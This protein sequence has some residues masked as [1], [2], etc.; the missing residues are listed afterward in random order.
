[1]ATFSDDTTAIREWAEEAL[2]IYRSLGNQW[3]VADALSSLGI[4]YGEGGDWARARPL[5]DESLQRF[6]EVG[7][8]VRAM[9]GTRSLAWATAEVG[10]LP[11]ARALYEDALRQGRAAGNRLLESVVLG[12]LSWLAI[13]EGRVADTPALLKESLRIKQDMGNLLE[14]AVGLCHAA[15][16]L[17]TVGRLDTAAQLIASYE[18][19]S[20]EIGSWPWVNRMKDETLQILHAQIDPQGFE[21]AWTQGRRLSADKAIALALDALEALAEQSTGDVT[22]A[23]AQP[24]PARP[25]GGGG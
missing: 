16:T 20:E 19:L 21:L 11:G 14:T 18:A 7:D 25:P 1:M 23:Y 3:G 2:E 5:F 10:D 12:S 4:G 24:E 9:W 15:Q 22:D 8:E 6:R 17:A 13:R